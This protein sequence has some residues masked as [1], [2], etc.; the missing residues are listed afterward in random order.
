MCVKTV[1]WSRQWPPRVAWGQL[2]FGNI[3]KQALDWHVWVKISLNLLFSL[4]SGYNRRTLVVTTK[5]DY[6]MDWEWKIAAAQLPPSPAAAN[7]C[8]SCPASCLLAVTGCHFHATCTIRNWDQSR[9]ML[10]WV[11]WCLRSMVLVWHWLPV[12][13]TMVE[14]V[15]GVPFLTHIISHTRACQPNTDRQTDRLSGGNWASQNWASVGQQLK[16]NSG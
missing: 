6:Y 5:M 15:P 11:K 14:N 13:H 7:C 9:T 3:W 2:H 4:V 10:G 12:Q 16:F 8:Q 1:E